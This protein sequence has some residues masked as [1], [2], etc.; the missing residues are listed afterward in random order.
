MIYF[1]RRNRMKIKKKVCAANWSYFSPK[2]GEDQKK[3]AFAAIRDHFQ[4]EIC[5]IF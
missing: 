3:K 4:Q 1:R 5:R 2:S